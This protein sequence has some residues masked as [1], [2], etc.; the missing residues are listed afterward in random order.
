MS[1]DERFGL[2]AEDLRSLVDCICKNDKVCEVILY[3]SR[4]K[5][6]YGQFSDI[7]LTLKGERL[8]HQDL[9]EIAENIDELL[10]P[11]EVDLSLYDDLDYAPLLE[12]ISVY[13]QPLKSVIRK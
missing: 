4:A 2:S 5:G 8:T 9:S 10:L 3:G 1:N 13:G 12:E 11:Y 6:N 7:D